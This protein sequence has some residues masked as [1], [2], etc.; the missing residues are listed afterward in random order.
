MASPFVRRLASAA[1]EANT[2]SGGTPRAT[3]S[4]TRRSAAC[5]SAS[6]CSSARAWTFALAAATSSC[7]IPA[8]AR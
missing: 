2:W 3:S 1:K 6:R 7:S 4:A 5:S 8:A